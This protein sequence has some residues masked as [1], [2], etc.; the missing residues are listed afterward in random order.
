[1]NRKV[2]YLNDSIMGFTIL[3]IKNKWRISK[4]GNKHKLYNGCI[5]SWIYNAYGYA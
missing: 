3:I 1:M 5:K 2:Y 4:V